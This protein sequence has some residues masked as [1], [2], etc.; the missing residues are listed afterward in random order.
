M[1]ADWNEVDHLWSIV[2]RLKG[3]FIEND[4]A[5]SIIDRYD[6]P[7]TLF[8]L[9]P[10]YLAGTRTERWRFSG[11]KCEI[12]EEYHRALL[13][14][15]QALQ[16]MAVISGY[17]SALYE[18]VLAGWQR[19]ESGSRTTNTSK[20]ATEVIWISPATALAQ[21]QQPLFAEVTL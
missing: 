6:Q 15:L 8:Y 5:M 7:H 13:D 16:G 4:D 9:D 3:A 19:F 14:R 1:I 10:P 20:V 17:P 21:D 11:Y 2:W 12:D 18:E